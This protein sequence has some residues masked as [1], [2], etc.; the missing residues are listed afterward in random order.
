MRTRSQPGAY[1]GSSKQRAQEAATDARAEVVE[2]SEL[3][4]TN[5]CRQRACRAGSPPQRAGRPMRW[6]RASTP[7]K[8][9]GRDGLP[10]S[11]ELRG[12]PKDL[13][14]LRVSGFR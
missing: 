3:L 11:R 1:E 7:P 5:R 14:L 6:F 13:M 9:Y 12:R 2:V 10:S 4:K 8:K